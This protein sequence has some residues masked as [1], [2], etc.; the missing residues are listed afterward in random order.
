[1]QARELMRRRVITATPE[2]TLKELA[3]LFVNRR[4]T[5]APVVDRI[6]K[7]VG[8]VS[9]TDLVR[10][11]HEAGTPEVAT[12]HI[13]PEELQIKRGFQI[14]AP[15]F[16]RVKD[17]MTPKVISFEETTDI[18]EIASLMLRR[19]IHRVVITSKGKLAGI[20]TSMDMLKAI[21][22]GHGVAPVGTKA[23]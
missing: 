6:G 11:E 16:T 1:M 21:A 10:H 12:Y 13:E 8:V 20:L 5:G 14:E 15:D 19:R 2:M 18:A 22:A 4:I 23:G 17:V 9:Q 3:D 7:T